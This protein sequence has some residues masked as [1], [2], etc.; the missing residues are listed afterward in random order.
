[1]ARVK[2][3]KN[4]NLQLRIGENAKQVVNLVAKK[5]GDS[6]SE[7]VIKKAYEDYSKI[8]DDNDFESF[9]K[10]LKIHLDKFSIIQYK[11]IVSSIA[12]DEAYLL[13][14]YIEAKGMK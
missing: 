14:K 1:M 13:E 11:E 10:A 4:Q 3:L 9:K 6:I 8:I 7:Y 5:K 12:E 2:E